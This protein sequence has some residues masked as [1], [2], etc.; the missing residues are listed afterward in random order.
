MGARIVPNKFLKNVLT[1]AVFAY[2]EILRDRKDMIL[3]NQDGSEEYERSS[4]PLPPPKPDIETRSAKYNPMREAGM[5]APESQYR[6]QEP[7]EIT[8]T[9]PELYPRPQPEGED[10]PPPPQEVGLGLGMQV[11]PKPVEPPHPTEP[12]LP[13]Q[14]TTGTPAPEKPDPFAKADLGEFRKKYGAH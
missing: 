7:P 11:P 14:E 12:P 2:T 5:D 9:R 10:A 8:R 13:Q 6:Y 1:G 4:L 3:C